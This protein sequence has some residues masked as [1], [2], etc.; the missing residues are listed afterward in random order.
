MDMKKDFEKIMGKSERIALAS[1][2][3]NIPN[4]RILNFVY[5]KDEKILYFA[6]TK[7]DPKEKEFSQ[8][9]NV[10]FTTVPSRGLAHIRTH[11][12]TVKKSKKTIFDV[13]DIFIAKMPWY[14][15]NI[16]ENGKT[17][18]LYEVHFTTAM[19]LAGPDKAAEIEL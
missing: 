19:V 12:A 2:V 15:E 9:H 1:S 18:D 4:V 5:S 3:E 13:Q 6:S 10:A 11:N 8:N 17:M 7:G 14:K 16:A